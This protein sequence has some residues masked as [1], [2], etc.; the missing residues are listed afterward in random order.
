M[1]EEVRRA[2]G[3]I[4]G[5]EERGYAMFLYRGWQRVG[6]GT[7]WDPETGKRIVMKDGGLLPA[8]R[9]ET[10]LRLPEGYLLIPLLLVGFGLSVA[11]PYGIG[12][13]V[14]VLMVVYHRMLSLLIG[15]CE[16]LCMSALA[17]VPVRYKPLLSFFSGTAKRPK[18]REK[19]KR[20]NK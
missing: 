7:Y 1:S 9:K 6:K 14:F 11:V 10:Y 13:V 18:P 17:Y 20:G 8:H 3:H 5:L 16:R 2:H 19:G 15:G 12:V 4:G